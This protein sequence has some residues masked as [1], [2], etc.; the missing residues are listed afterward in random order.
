MISLKGYKTLKLSGYSRAAHR[1]GIEIIGLN[2]LLDAGLDV[3]KAFSHIFITH[4][5]LDHVIYLPQYTMNIENDRQYINVISTNN[6]LNNIKPYLCEALKMSKNINCD[7]YEDILKKVNTNFIPIDYNNNYKFC[8]GREQW[9]VNIIKCYHGIDSIG[10]GFS[11]IKNK[12]KEEYINLTN[13]EIIKLKNEGQIITNEIKED[14]FLFLGDTNKKILQNKDIY[15]YKSIIIECTYIY[16]E[17]M[18][19]AKINKHIHWLDIKNIIIENKDIQFILIH[20][21]MKY[22]N[23]EIKDFFNKENITNIDIFI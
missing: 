3:Q 11:V 8:N 23:Q 9:I 6:I 4:Q 2:I 13:Q 19:L 15:K 16:D 14:I 17:E 20:F 12:L 21:S 22:K 1:T 7:N 5:H 10:F 18:D